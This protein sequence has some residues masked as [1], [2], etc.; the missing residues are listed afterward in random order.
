MVCAACVRR[1]ANR[2]NNSKIG[3]L[4]T[5]DLILLVDDETA[6]RQIVFDR[7]IREEATPLRNCCQPQFDALMRRLVRDLAAVH[8]D[9]TADRF[10]TVP[11]IA[12]I[13]VVLPAPFEPRTTVID[14]LSILTETLSRAT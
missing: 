12:L 4:A 8:P 5:F 11:A 2:G 14:P 1:S 3:V 13:S 6:K 9:R 10:G 7:H